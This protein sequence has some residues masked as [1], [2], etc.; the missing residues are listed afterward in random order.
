MQPPSK[1]GPLEG[2][3][4]VVELERWVEVKNNPDEVFEAWC[5]HRDARESLA[6][7]TGYIGHDGGSDGRFWFPAQVFAVFTKG[8]TFVTTPG[9]AATLH[10]G[11]HVP[12]SLLTPPSL[13]M[14][15]FQFA[16]DRLAPPLAMDAD[17]PTGNID[18]VV[19]PIR[20]NIHA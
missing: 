14:R 20:R 8:V 2:L 19:R 4:K 16:L 10:H 7:W 6:K 3:W 13:L 5:R 18:Y 9:S 11:S 12:R 17:D 1:A 15:L